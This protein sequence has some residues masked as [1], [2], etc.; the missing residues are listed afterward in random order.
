LMGEASKQ[1]NSWAT[2]GRSS[3]SQTL[4]R[5]YMRSSVFLFAI[6]VS[7]W[8][9]GRSS[10]SPLQ[11]AVDFTRVNRLIAAACKEH[12]NVPQELVWA[13]IWTESRYDS[14]VLGNRGE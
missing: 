8:A 10:V 2:S 13:L 6:I 7:S 9:Q 4:G 12:K 3:E 1:R 5:L 14:A 11:N